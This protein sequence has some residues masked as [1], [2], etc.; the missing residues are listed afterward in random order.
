MMPLVLEILQSQTIPIEVDEVRLEAVRTQSAGEVSAT[1]IQYGN[2]RVPLG[3]LFRVSGSAAEDDTVVWQGNCSA[4]KLVGQGWVRGRIVVEGSAGMHCGAQLR[5]GVIEV[6]G[7]AADWLG[8]EMRGG[9]IRV[10]GNAG[11]CV[12]GMYRGGRRGMNGGEILIDGNAGDELGH[13]LRRGL[14]AIGGRAGE[15]VGFNMRAGTILL[16]GGSGIRPGAGM[17]RGTIAYLGTSGAPPLLPTFRSAGLVDP[18]FLRIYLKHLEQAGF[19][20]SGV[21]PEGETARYQGDFLEAG[22]GEIFVRR[23]A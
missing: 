16:F 12:G 17:R 19:D 1:L 20:L 22:R 6:R 4:V 15:G 21:A 5:G 3:E 11:D 13:T 10:R 18:L 9:C 14:I 2:Q 23:A 8:A 7:D